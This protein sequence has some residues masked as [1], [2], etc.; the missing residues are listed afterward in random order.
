[1]VNEGRGRVGIEEDTVLV[2]VRGC[3]G[4]CGHGG[5]FI[6]VPTRLLGNRDIPRRHRLPSVK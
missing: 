2:E 1:M 6:D 5:W 3:Y 4:V